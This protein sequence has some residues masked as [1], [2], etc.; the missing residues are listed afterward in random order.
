MRIKM[1][2]ALHLP[3][4]VT[5]TKKAHT[6]TTM[7]H[8]RALVLECAVTLGFARGP[9]L[10]KAGPKNQISMSHLGFLRSN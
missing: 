1:C 10:Q 3:Y 7:R 8:S 2:N 9:S 4:T 6:H 5:V